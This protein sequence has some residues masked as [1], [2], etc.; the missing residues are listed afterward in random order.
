MKNKIIFTSFLLLYIVFIII[1]T[2]LDLSIESNSFKKFK[3]QESIKNIADYQ[4]DINITNLSI[5]E[6]W[7]LQ[8]FKSKELNITKD[9]NKTIIKEID[10]QLRD[11]NGFYTIIISQ[12]EFDVL[13]VA[14]KGEELFVILYDTNITKRRDAI[15]KYYKNDIIYKNTRIQK[16]DKNCLLIVDSKTH[17]KLK[18]PYFF[19]D[20]KD[21][22]PK[23]ENNDY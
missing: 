22:K 23:G 12:K 14:Q 19:V 2:I 4:K 9:L 20:S 15:K 10:I 1:S 17:T 18:V 16:I 5:N 11:T 6:I 8:Q 13:G 7:G 21:F 3:N